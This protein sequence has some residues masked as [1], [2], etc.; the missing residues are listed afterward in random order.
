MRGRTECL[1][2]VK[3]LCVH[4]GKI[5][6]VIEIGNTCSKLILTIDGRK[7]TTNNLNNYFINFLTRSLNVFTNHT[8]NLPATPTD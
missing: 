6:Q 8:T 3:N 5:P 4:R 1:A 2:W 7:K